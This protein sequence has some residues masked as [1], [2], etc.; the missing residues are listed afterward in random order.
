MMMMMMMVMMVLVM[1]MQMMM[2]IICVW[3]VA[4]RRACHMLPW[5]AR[6]TWYPGQ[7]KAKEKHC[8]V[9]FSTTESE[10]LLR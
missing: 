9:E 2:M 1:L 3:H 6:V 7:S 10:S 4:P 5:G 8:N